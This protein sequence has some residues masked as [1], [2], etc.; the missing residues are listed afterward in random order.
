MS[1]LD[2]DKMKKGGLIVMVFMRPEKS[3]N[4]GAIKKKKEHNKY[5]QKIT[6]INDNIHHHP[7]TSRG[8]VTA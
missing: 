5:Q 3:E 8:C 7:F 1:S 4:E 6:T 2:A